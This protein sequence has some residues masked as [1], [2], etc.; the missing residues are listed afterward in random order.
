MLVVIIWLVLSIVIG[1]AAAHRGRSGLAWLFFS[2]IL[3]P[4]I[5]ALILAALPDRKSQK[6]LQKIRA[7][8]LEDP[9]AA[10]RMAAEG[11]RRAL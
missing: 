11:A 4:L 2:L 6:E 1:A 8:A 9:A 3:S 7:A 10:R 5:A